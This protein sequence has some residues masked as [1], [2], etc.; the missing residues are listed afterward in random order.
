M[1]LSVFLAIFCSLKTPIPENAYWRGPGEGKSLSPTGLK[2]MLAAHTPVAPVLQ[3]IPFLPHCPYCTIMG[4]FSLALLENNQLV[5]IE[6]QISFRP[7]L[8]F[9]P[10]NFYC[11]LHVKNNTNTT[12]TATHVGIVWHSVK[13]LAE[14]CLRMG[15]S[16]F[17]AAV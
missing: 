2:M 4:N 3:I 7:C 16:R 8:S 1:L 9:Q 13:G 10:E 17:K 11:A 12:V 15:R 5:V 14:K 6:K